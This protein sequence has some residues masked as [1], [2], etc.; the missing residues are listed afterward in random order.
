MS[1]GGL[2]WYTS[3]FSASM[4]RVSRINSGTSTTLKLEGKLLGPWVGE[5]ARLLGDNSVC[6]PIHLD[7]TAVSFVDG[8]GAQLLRDLISSGTTIVACSSFV[9]ELLATEAR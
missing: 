9:A 2:N 8:P 7:L 1:A 4:L 5:L 6:S 3:R